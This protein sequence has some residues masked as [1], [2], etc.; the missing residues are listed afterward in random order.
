MF[1][2]SE[3]A[4]NAIKKSELVQKIIALNGKF[5]V[6]SDISNL[7]NQISK[8]NDRTFQLHSTN[9]KIRSEVTVV[10][11]VNTKRKEKIISLKKNQAKSEQYC[12][13]NNIE[14]SGIPNDIP[15]DDQQEVVIGIYHH[16]GLEIEPK[17]VERYH[18]LPASRYSRDFNKRVI[19][20]FIN[21]KHPEAL[22]RNKKPISSK[23]FRYL[24]VHGKV[25]VSVSLC[26]Y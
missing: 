5:L 26:P 25:F 17:D 6:D 8:L 13:C 21:R 11:N 23:D 9:E 15:E 2:L 14:W 10:K 20:K 7:R 1:T 16:F 12:R 4:I 18:R 19:V 22:L 24:N 3:S